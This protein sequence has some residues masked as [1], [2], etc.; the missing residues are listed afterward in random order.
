MKFDVI[1]F[2]H[3]DAT[4]KQA[5]L[6]SNSLLAFDGLFQRGLVASQ[7]FKSL[8]MI[9]CVFFGFSRIRVSTIISRFGCLLSPTALSKLNCKLWDLFNDAQRISLRKLCFSSKDI[10]LNR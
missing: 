8:R 5:Y 1:I 4:V 6:L 7:D 2:V 10:L 9:Y 3:S